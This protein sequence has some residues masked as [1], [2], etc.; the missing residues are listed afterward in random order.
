MMRINIELDTEN[1]ADLTALSAL[2]M[3]L[4]GDTP[5]D[6]GS[7][8]APP[9]PPAADAP[10][11]PPAT[12]AP[13]PPA[14]PASETL[15]EAE[16]NRA[17]G[18]G[19]APD[20]DKTGLPYDARIHSSTKAVNND[21]SWRNKRNVDAAL[22]ASVTAELRAKVAQPAADAPPP[23]TPEAAFSPPADASA[24]PAPPPGE[25]Q[26]PAPPAPPAAD[27]PPPPPAD[28]ADPAGVTYPAIIKAA[29]DK[30]MTYDQLNQ[31]AIT[32]GLAAFKDLVKRPD[33][34]ESFM[35]SIG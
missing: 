10:P 8:D 25:Q 35:A 33:L 4:R 30:G 32:L 34:F 16:A 3:S 28:G 7:P 20:V 5:E 26:P 14:P 13:A 31:T 6:F 27:A 15:I 11:P 12:V 29:N 18:A 1:R 17:A 21:G 22:L 19:A 9:A 24:P 23:Q 2:I